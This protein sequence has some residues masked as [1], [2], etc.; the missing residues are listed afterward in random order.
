MMSKQ[1]SPPH[2]NDHLRDQLHRLAAR[3][4]SLFGFALARLRVARGLTVQDQAAALGIEEDGLATLAVCRR[5]RPERRQED[6][7][8][9]ARRVGVGVEVL[10]AV[11]ADSRP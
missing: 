4:P 1:S 6:L 3:E 9:V 5:P 8:A 7:A 11:L 10:E 2:L